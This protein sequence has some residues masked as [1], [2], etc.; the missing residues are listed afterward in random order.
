[1][2]LLKEWCAL[3]PGKQL[4]KVLLPQGT[5]ANNRRR[6]VENARVSHCLWNSDDIKLISEMSDPY[7]NPDALP[8]STIEAIITR[9]EERGRH[10]F[11]L[12][13]INQYAAVLE[14]DRK[15]SILELGCGTGVVIR[16]I[17]TLV[18]PSSVLRAADISE[19]FLQCSPPSPSPPPPPSLHQTTLQP[20]HGICSCKRSRLKIVTD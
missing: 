8:P 11:F 9:L 16:H 18:H 17:E 2:F 1:V 19:Q 15:L 3:A 5:E 7:H 4:V 6:R 12:A 13:A 20:S 10:P 14:R